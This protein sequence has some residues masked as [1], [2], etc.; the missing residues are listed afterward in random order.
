ME[1]EGP[2]RPPGLERLVPLAE[3]LVQLGQAAAAA[4][5]ERVVGEGLVEAGPGLIP[6]ALTDMQKEKLRRSA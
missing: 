1:A 6:D 2:G 3:P 5:V 4:E